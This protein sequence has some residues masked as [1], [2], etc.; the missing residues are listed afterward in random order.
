MTG[1]VL[2]R[3]VREA[4]L[5]IFFEQQLDPEANVMAAFVA[6]D[7]TDR[8]AFMAHWARILGD[9]RNTTLTIV[10]DGQVAGHI[11]SFEHFGKPSVSYWL[12]RDYWSRGV[13]TRALA[14]L[15]RRIPTRPL[16]ARAAKDNHGSLRVLE[17]CGFTICGEDTGFANARSQEI[18][19]LILILRE[20]S[21]GKSRATHGTA[22]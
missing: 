18:E 11:A 1:D 21:D 13:A 2:L 3:E 20:P 16:Y 6:E 9:E 4:D 22:Q 8:E 14:E 15:L 10:V 19:E 7:P 17:K 5:P 12:G